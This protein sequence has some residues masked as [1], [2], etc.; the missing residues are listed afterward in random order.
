MCGIAGF[1]D[2]SGRITDVDAAMTAMS[3]AIRHRGPDGEGRS[4]DPARQVALV[5]HRLAIQDTSDEGAQPMFSAS[6]RYEIVYNGEI[7]DFPERRRDLETAGR[8]F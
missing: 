5:H 8:R 6:G 1:I 3:D 7:Y 4:F 2:G